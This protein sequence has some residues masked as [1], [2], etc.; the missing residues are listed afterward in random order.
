MVFGSDRREFLS[1]E[2]RENEKRIALT[3]FIEISIPQWIERC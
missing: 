1:R 2:I 3:L